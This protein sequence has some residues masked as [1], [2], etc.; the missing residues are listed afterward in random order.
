MAYW[1]DS[2]ICTTNFCTFVTT[3]LSS[4][5]LDKKNRE[6]MKKRENKNTCEYKRYDCHKSC[7][8]VVVQISF[9]Y[10]RNDF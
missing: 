1:N 6:S 3:T 10:L 2:D 7:Q 8:K 4:F 5:L 9:L